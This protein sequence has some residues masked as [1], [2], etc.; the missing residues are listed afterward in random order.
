MVYAD[1]GFYPIEVDTPDGTA[2]TE[3]VGYFQVTSEYGGGS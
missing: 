1:P 2:T 3:N